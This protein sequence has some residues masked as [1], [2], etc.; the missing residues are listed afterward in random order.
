MTTFR[1]L[2][3]LDLGEYLFSL[4]LKARHL[5]GLRIV[6]YA[7]Y[8]I[9][10]GCFSYESTVGYPLKLL[11]DL[12][13]FSQHH[14]IIREIQGRILISYMTYFACLAALMGLEYVL[15]RSY[16]FEYRADDDKASRIS[17]KICIGI[18]CIAA[19]VLLTRFFL[20]F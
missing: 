18:G 20:P 7:V 19:L 11:P 9:G 8:I 16:W 15:L 13:Q 14:F 10:L 5:W 2:I 17:K 3:S 12:G 6:V 1:K 4:I